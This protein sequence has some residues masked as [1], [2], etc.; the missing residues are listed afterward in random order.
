MSGRRTSRETMTRVKR[1]ARMKRHNID[2]VDRAGLARSVSYCRQRRTAARLPPRAHRA[3]FG[4][5]RQQL[6]LRFGELG[7]AL[8]HERLF[9]F[10]DVNLAVDL[11]NDL[12]GRKAVDLPCEGQ[13]AL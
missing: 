4:H 6:L 8:F 9:K 11:L 12:R 3:L 5:R 13:A 2:G 7:D 1:L 10:G